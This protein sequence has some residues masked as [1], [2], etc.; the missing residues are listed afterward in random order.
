MY[1]KR[2]HIHFMGIGGIGMSGIAEILKL[3]GYSVSGCDLTSMSKTIEHLQKIG[4]QVYCEHSRCH[5]KD[6]DV[7]VY[8]SAVDKQHPEILTALE[9]G[10]PVI[11]RAIMLA[12][13]MRTKFSVAVSGTH[14]KTTTTSLISHIMIEA[15]VQPTVIIGGVLKSIGNNVQLGRGSFL[16]A[17]AD[18]SDKSLLYLHPT[19]AVVTNIDNDH[20]DTYKDINDIKNTFKDFLVRMPFY[21]KAFL[22]I[23]D[24]NIQSIL[25][26]QHI[27]V[28]KYGFSESADL[29]GEIVRI[30]QTQTDFNVYKNQVNVSSGKCFKSFLGSVT[31][32]MPGQHNVL[33]ALAATALCMEFDIPFESIVA[34]LKSFKGVERRFEFKGIFRGADVF[35]DYGHHPTEIKNTLI[36]AQRRKNKRLHVV[37]QPHRF[38]RTQKCWNEFIE[39]LSG[40]NSQYKID[41][42]YITDIY[43]ASEKPISGITSENLAKQIK[44]KNP[45]LKVICMPTYEQITQIITQEIEEG[46]LVL[47]LGAGKVNKIAETLI[48]SK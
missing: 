15:G 44:E 31:L 40:L 21:G 9:K 8:S 36:V 38:S 13:L 10:I 32:N 33:N 18:E 14:G 11:P 29:M 46:D 43:P 4:C 22:C 1:K 41:L 30:E 5:V 7:L 6:A 20:L 19:M 39:V 2:E 3:Q 25:P 34:S 45:R 16:I 28:V 24:S 47:T 42:L 35:D 12:E 48:S 27:N 17:E 23:D 26:L 37:F